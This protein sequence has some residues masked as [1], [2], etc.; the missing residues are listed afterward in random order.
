MSY[1][2]LFKE[3]NNLVLERLRLSFDRISEIKNENSVEEPFLDYFKSVVTFIEIIEVIINEI[4]SGDFEK[5]SITELKELNN[6]LYEDI[7]L[8]NYEKSYSNPKYA[9]DKLGFEYGQL[10][11]FLYVEIRGVIGAAFEYRLEPIAVS[12]ELFIEIYNMFECIEDLT[13]KAVK[14]TIYWYASDYC[15]VFVS[16][17]VREMVDT[18]L[19]FAEKIVVDSD[20]SDLSYLYKYGEYISESDYKLAE[21]MNTLP[22][23]KVKLM[24]DTYVE[25]YRKGFEL[26]GIDLTK[27]ESVAIRFPIG[28]ER[29]VAIAIKSFKNLGLKPVIYRHALNAVNK[30]ARGRIGYSGSSANR[31]YDYDHRFDH[32]LYTDKEFIDRKLGVYKSTFEIYKEQANKHAGPAVIESFGAVKFDAVNYKEALSLTEKQRKLEIAYANE[33]GRITN[34]YIPGDE[35]SFTIIAFPVPEI[36][37]NF[38]EIFEEIIHINTLDYELYENIQQTI[39]DTLD[40]AEYVRIL[41]RDGNKTDI[42]VYLQEIKNPEK[43]TKFEN[44]VADVNIPLG[45]VFTSPKLNGTNGKLFVS[46]VYLEGTFFKNL[47]IEFKDGM[48]ADYSCENFDSEE[49]NRKLIE[50]NILFQHDTLPLGEFAIGT[51][52]TAY[53]VA[54]KYDI[55]D[56]LPIL[57]AEKMGP[58]FAVGDTC[59]TWSEDTTIYNPNGKEIIAKENEVSALRK[60]DI[61]KAYMNCHTDITIPYHEL[62]EIIAVTSSGD[63]LHIISKGKFVLKGTEELNYP[64]NNI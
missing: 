28:M 44:C 55:F 59:Y 32:A 18:A 20:L 23:A 30:S 38:A 5:K 29:M 48:I 7:Y 63:E 3:E 39:I 43:E 54:V 19:D 11:S 34:T 46:G 9:V 33:A 16:H 22:E 17:R 10:L 35:R 26:E 1:L 56:K 36:G 8:V 47:C 14:D 52:T 13:Y 4:K 24:A 2:E 62:G 40:K 50:A 12:L 64:L 31:Q 41:G 37:E 27:K 45:E 61:S 53:A 15:D 49:E 60:E 21:F 57:I 51:N 42:K 58:H 25:G 6:K